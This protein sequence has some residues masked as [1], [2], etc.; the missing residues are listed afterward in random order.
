MD[1]D[2]AMTQRGW[3]HRCFDEQIA[4]I[5]QDRTDELIERHYQPDAVL[6]SFQGIVRGHEALRRHFRSYMQKLG[7][8]TMPSLDQFAETQDTLFFEAS[9]STSLGEARVYDA[10]VLRDGKVTHHFTGIK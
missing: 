3:G 1:S 9:V 4:L 2:S 5:E 7:K 8:L 10:F 6:V